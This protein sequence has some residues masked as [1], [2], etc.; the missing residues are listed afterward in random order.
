MLKKLLVGSCCT[1]GF[2]LN[3]ALPIPQDAKIELI[4]DQAKWSEGPVVLKD[5]TIIWSDIENNKVLQWNEKEGV[6]TWLFPSQF[7]NGHA[8][9]LEGRVVAASHGKR[10]IERLETDGH[11]NVLVDLYGD[12]KLNSPNDLIID[13][14]GDIWFTDPVFG[15]QKESEGYGGN[16]V[17]GGEFS[18]RFSPKTNKLIRLVTPEVKTPNGIALSPDQKKLYLTD[19]QIAHDSSN[20][21]LNH[22][23]FVYD[24]DENK[25]TT[26]G[27]MLAKIDTGTPDGIAV[28]DEGNIWVTGGNYI[29]VFTEQGKYL[30]Q[31]KFPTQVAN[32]VFTR[33]ENGTRVVYITGGTSLYRLTV[34]VGAAQ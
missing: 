11:W 10:A 2:S 32:M 8:I 9:D 6:R 5:G 3:A 1:I 27:K 24:I 26:H 33:L 16:A 18:Y 17:V 4:T 13:K 14:D 30:G 7:Q 15:I 19:S 12:K 21:K 25:Q 29:H 31:L 28:D 23:L 22:H 34:Y 20:S